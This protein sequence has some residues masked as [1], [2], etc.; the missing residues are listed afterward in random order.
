MNYQLPLLMQSSTDEHFLD[1]AVLTD[2]DKSLS[3]IAK[4]REESSKH[5]RILQ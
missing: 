3:V 4:K 5:L 1:G 2:N